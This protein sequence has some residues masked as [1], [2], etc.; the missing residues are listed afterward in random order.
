MRIHTK[1]DWKR[2]REI[3]ERNDM[4]ERLAGTDCYARDDLDRPPYD[5][6]GIHQHEKDQFECATVLLV[7]DGEMVL[8][9]RP[10]GRLV[11]ARIS[12]PRTRCRRVG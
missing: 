8:L 7:E 3:R 1:A 10:D 4:A 11:R 6:I 5:D 12:V 2:W 9:E